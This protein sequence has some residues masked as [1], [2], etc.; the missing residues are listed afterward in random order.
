L[1]GQGGAEEAIAEIAVL[2]GLW[3][4]SGIIEFPIDGP[5]PDKSDDDP[6]DAP[7]IDPSWGFKKENPFK[8]SPRGA[9]YLGLG[10]NSIDLKRSHSHRSDKSN[11]QLKDN[12][13][14][15]PRSHFN[16]ASAA[17]QNVPPFV[18]FVVTALSV[19][20]FAAKGSERWV[21]FFAVLML[22]MVVHSAIVCG[23]PPRVEVIISGAWPLFLCAT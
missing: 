2:V 18:I 3:N 21:T 19:A 8:Q 23:C 17:I 6:S 1:T 5:D 20:L 9:L 11:G 12:E 4:G 16:T 22:P 13:I 7:D 14:P 10:E 15:Q